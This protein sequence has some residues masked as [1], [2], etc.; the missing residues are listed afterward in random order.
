VSARGANGVVAGSWFKFVGFQAV[1]KTVSYRTPESTKQ[2]TAKPKLVQ[3][4]KAAEYQH[5]KQHKKKPRKTAGLGVSNRIKPAYLLR[6]RS[7]NAGTNSKL[8][9]PK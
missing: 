6:R 4:D 1:V 9:Q 3:H 5:S 8:N 2:K 7:H